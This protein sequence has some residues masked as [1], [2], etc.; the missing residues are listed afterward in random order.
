MQGYFAKFFF[1]SQTDVMKNLG[2]ILTDSSHTEN[3]FPTNLENG[4]VQCQF[5]PNSFAYA[6]SLKVHEEEIHGAKAPES[7]NHVKRLRTK[8]GFTVSYFSDLHCFIKI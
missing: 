2:C 3:N 1:G 4:R 8:W 5:F 7:N 6:G